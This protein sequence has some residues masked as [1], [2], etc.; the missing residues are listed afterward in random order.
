MTGGISDTKKDRFILGACFGQRIFV[1]GVPVHRV[2][3]MLK[4][5]WGGFVDQTVGVF[6]VS[7]AIPFKEE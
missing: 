5:I 2:V 3:S 6:V 4:Q 1:P 7:H